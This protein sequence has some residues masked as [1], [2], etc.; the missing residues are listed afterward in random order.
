LAT[1]SL[2]ERE[3]RRERARLCGKGA[4]EAAGRGAPT[5]LFPPLPPFASLGP[6]AL[7]DLLR[8]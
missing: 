8:V 1:W 2:E 6:R 5:L 4:G 3:R 7:F